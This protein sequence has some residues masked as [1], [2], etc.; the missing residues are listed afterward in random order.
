MW[1]LKQPFAKHLYAIKHF[2][3]ALV[4][5]A[6]IHY[7]LDGNY[8]Y[9]TWRRNDRP[10]AWLSTAKHP[11][12]VPDERKHD[13]LTG[14]VQFTIPSTGEVY[15]RERLSFT[16]WKV[17]TGPN[18]KVEKIDQKDDRFIDYVVASGW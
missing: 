13:A 8:Y 18:A 12:P 15:H 7:S 10:R 4:T 16:F 5:T 11:G 14:W 3:V 17:R 2:I 6:E 9:V 1:L